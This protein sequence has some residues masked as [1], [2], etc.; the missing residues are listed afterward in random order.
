MLWNYF[1]TC[2]GEQSCRALALIPI[3]GELGRTDL[4][5]HSHPLFE[6]CIQVAKNDDVQPV[7]CCVDPY[8][9]TWCMERGYDYLKIEEGMSLV[10]IAVKAISQYT[11]DIIF[12]LDP[13]YPV[14]PRGI[15][16]SMRAV[17]LSKGVAS[18]SAGKIGLFDADVVKKTYQCSP[19]RSHI[20]LP[21]PNVCTEEIVY[22]PTDKNCMHVHTNVEKLFCNVLDPWYEPKEISVIVGGGDSKIK[23]DSLKVKVSSTRYQ[24]TPPD[25]KYDLVISDLPTEDATYILSTLG[26][27]N[28]GC[29]FH[30]LS[31]LAKTISFLS[32]IYP[33]VK[34]QWYGD[35][36]LKLENEL[37][38]RADNNL[39]RRRA[40]SEDYI[41][42]KTFWAQLNDTLT[43]SDWKNTNVR[44]QEEGTI[45]LR[46]ISKSWS[47]NLIINPA[48][49]R[50]YRERNSDPFTI[51]SY[52]PD[53]E[54]RIKW[55]NWDEEIFYRI[56]KLNLWK[57]G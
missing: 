25:R 26:W 56:G 43:Q 42:E 13:A 19:F 50:G 27:E 36:T 48:Q 40:E 14:I 12:L 45:S 7:I 1:C 8:I 21:L 47:D 44:L 52:L 37:I 3:F 51:L 11:P 55:D 9:H 28:K 33:E 2:K 17:Y 35:R 6:W 10:D 29:L 54:L 18:L 53:S 38:Q 24:I 32:L 46:V 23:E 49:R 34:I 16:R 22:T 20:Y 57:R 39:E 31:P 4:T 5:I 30:R 15:L 41:I